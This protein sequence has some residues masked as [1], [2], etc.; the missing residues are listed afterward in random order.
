MI[1]GG[2]RCSQKSAESGV[3]STGSSGNENKSFGV[4][5]ADWVKVV[6]AVMETVTDGLGLLVTVGTWAEKEVDVGLE[7]KDLS[8]SQPDKTRLQRTQNMIIV[9]LDL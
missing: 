9:K 7:A 1:C 3:L 6:V 4:M 5:F 8:P 2:G